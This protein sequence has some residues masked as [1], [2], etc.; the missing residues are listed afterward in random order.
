MKSIIHY[1]LGILVSLLLALFVYRDPSLFDIKLALGLIVTFVY[2]EL[3]F[4]KGYS[5]K[6]LI[7]GSLGILVV[8]VTIL[9]IAKMNI[10]MLSGLV[11]MFYLEAISKKKETSSIEPSP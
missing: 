9:F 5:N 11:L 6:M 3:V 10:G 7:V 4:R 1:I 2:G 8:V